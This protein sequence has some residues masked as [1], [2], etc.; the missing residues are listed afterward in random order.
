MEYFYNKKYLRII[1]EIKLYLS[2]QQN[3]TYIPSR[4]IANMKMKEPNP[5]GIDQRLSQQ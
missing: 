3:V 1:L 5:K 4:N 2:G